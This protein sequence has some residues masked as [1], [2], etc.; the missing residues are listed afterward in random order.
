MTAEDYC[1]ICYPV[2]AHA[3]GAPCHWCYDQARR[4]QIT[5]DELDRYQV[6]VLKT[7][8]QRGADPFLLRAI[9]VGMLEKATQQEMDDYRSSDAAP[10]WVRKMF[11]I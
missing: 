11:P 5:I 6:L 2:S 3:T 9:K 8:P 4:L 10:C 1:R 7:I